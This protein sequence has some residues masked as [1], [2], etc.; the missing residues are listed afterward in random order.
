MRDI[1]WV[2][3]VGA[4]VLAVSTYAAFEPVVISGALAAIVF[5]ALLA[6]TFKKFIRGRTV[7]AAKWSLV[8]L[9]FPF[10]CSLRSVNM[11]AALVGMGGLFTVTLLSKTNPESLYAKKLPLVVMAVALLS[12]LVRPSNAQ[13]AIFLAL[14]FMVLLRACSRT[15]RH[16]AVT[17]LIDGVGL[18]L[19][20]NV[21]AYHVLGMRSAGA[22][23]RT[24]GLQS[25][26]GGVRVLYPLATSLNL[27][28]I[29]AAAFLSASLLL[30]E[31]GGRRVFRLLAVAASVVVLVGAE[32]RTALIVAAL[33]AVA[34][35]TA[36]RILRGLA[37]PVTIGS[38]VFVFI[39]PA[40][41]KTVVT[42]LVTAMAEIIPALSRNSI[43]NSDASLNGR[44]IIWFQASRFWVERTSDWGRIFGYGAQGQYESRAS[45]TYAYIFGSSV[46]DPY[47]TSTHNS[48]LQQL[49]DGGIVGAVCLVVAVIACVRLWVIRSRVNEP[50]TAAAL[51]MSV[52]LVISSVTE[53]SLAPGM[54]QETLLVFIGLLVAACAGSLERGDGNGSG[55]I[56]LE[57]PIRTDRL[58]ARVTSFGGV[59]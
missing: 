34:S 26:D 29:M 6:R 52:S 48:A 53:V 4:V 15:T 13:S 3:G 59:P 39:Y 32:S 21:A 12:V 55:D 11:T 22:V 19:I 38:L 30:L 28:P 40:I 47:M 36:S 17:S 18:Y 58:P 16:A 14:A 44:E 45:R 51:A 5:A 54:G 25:A 20:V 10:V 33:T 46:R 31:R 50:H 57:T 42:P 9:A 43:G 24:G 37:V 35:L 2:A 27:P 7:S 56:K 41:S 8:L 1:V 49:F 23:L